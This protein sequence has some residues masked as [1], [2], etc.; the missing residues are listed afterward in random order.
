MYSTDSP[1]FRVDRDRRSGF[2][3]FLVRE[4]KC[5]KRRERYWRIII[6]STL[7]FT[8]AT[9]L[10]SQHVPEI[11]QA[12]EMLSARVVMAARLY[13]PIPYLGNCCRSWSRTATASVRLIAFVPEKQTLALTFITYWFLPS[14]PKTP[15]STRT[16][17]TICAR[18][19]QRNSRFC[20]VSRSQRARRMKIHLVDRVAA[21]PPRTT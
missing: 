7:V 16:H 17:C 11:W 19:K 18:K 3:I 9:S 5:K 12:S 21:S 6:V 14:F 4:Y 1:I 15:P 2:H 10:R 8:A 13:D 20:D